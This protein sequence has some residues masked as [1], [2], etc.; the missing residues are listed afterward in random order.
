M[1]P[2]YFYIAGSTLIALGIGLFIIHKRMTAHDN[3]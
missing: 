1:K 3:T 2:K